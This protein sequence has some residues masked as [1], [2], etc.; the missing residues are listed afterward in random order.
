[1]SAEI[2]IGGQRYVCEL[3]EQFMFLSNSSK[4][5][6][7][8]KVRGPMKKGVSRCQYSV[9]YLLLYLIISWLM[10]AKTIHVIVFVKKMNH[11]T[12]LYRVLQRA[13]NFPVEGKYIYL[14]S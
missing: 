12:A 2:W 3:V 1:M 7:V 8:R 11:I 14:S 10:G 5:P 4:R 13:C 9:R 6:Y